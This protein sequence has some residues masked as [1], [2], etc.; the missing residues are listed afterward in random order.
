MSSSQGPT[1]H[2]F[3]GT[4]I[5]GSPTDR[6]VAFVGGSGYSGPAVYKTTDGG[7]S[8]TAMGAGLPS[9]L[10]FGLTF[11]NDAD[12]N[13]Y[14]AAEAGPYAYNT[15]T[16]TWSSILGAEGPL[17]SYWC[18]ESVPEIGVVRFGTYGRG[19]W[20]YRAL[21]PS[22]VAENPS[23][24]AGVRLIAAPN[25]AANRVTFSFEMVKA[26]RVRLDLFDVTGR[27]VSTVCD[28]SRAAGRQEIGYGLVAGVGRSLESGVYLARLTTPSGV[29]VEKL[30][31]L[32]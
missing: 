4:A 14:A 2:Y 21:N 15:Q 12:Q 24:A 28:E 5:I 32:R 27:R 29:D 3:Y 26:G 1:E 10:V 8:W 31:V 23:R 18:I 7:V 30:R 13:L 6:N 16:G 25:P 22:E 9:T 19:I 11:D 20:D 17:S